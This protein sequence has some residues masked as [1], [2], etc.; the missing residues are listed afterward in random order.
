MDNLMLT[1]I[2]DA[3]LKNFRENKGKEIAAIIVTCD[4]ISDQI[5]NDSV[6]SI[7]NFYCVMIESVYLTSDII[8]HL[9]IMDR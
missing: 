3:L 9:R 4:R 2:F 8:E 6:N 1:K 5:K 7:L